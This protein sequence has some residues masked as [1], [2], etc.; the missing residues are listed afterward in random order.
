MVKSSVF[1]KDLKKKKVPNK[2]NKLYESL[3]L[4]R[5]LAGI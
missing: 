4:G 3:K 1:C 2:S 5:S